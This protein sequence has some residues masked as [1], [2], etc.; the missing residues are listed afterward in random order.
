MNTVC[1]EIPAYL[2]RG[3]KRFVD[4]MAQ[5]EP[6]IRSHIQ[7][8]MVYRLECGFCNRSAEY[9]SVTL[10]ESIISFLQ[11]GWRQVYFPHQNKLN[12][13]CCVCVNKLKR[14]ELKIGDSDANSQ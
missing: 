8:S 12:I 1:I 11:Q 10:P 9:S 2:E 6:S 14:N 7:I 3:V 5:R 13:A 4:S